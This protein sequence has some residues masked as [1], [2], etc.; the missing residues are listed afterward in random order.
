VRTGFASGALPASRLL[1]PRPACR[2]R[3]RSSATP[4]GPQLRTGAR[5]SRARP[6]RTSVDAPRCVDGASTARTDA[7][8]THA[9]P[10]STTRETEEST[11][12]P[13]LRRFD[14]L[15]FRHRARA[16]KDSRMRSACTKEV[17]NSVARRDGDQGEGA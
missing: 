15:R 7:T 5:S 4:R 16:R 12:N 17:R 13:P 6:P 3:G 10:V 8:N 1:A 2:G 9:N 14:G 11:A